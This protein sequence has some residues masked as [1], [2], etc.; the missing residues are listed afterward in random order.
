[1]MLELD[2]R[3]E[4]AA[5]YRLACFVNMGCR[6][7]EVVTF[8]VEFNDT[9]V[10]EVPS[11]ILDGREFAGGHV[12]A[13]PRFL[14][15]GRRDCHARSYPNNGLEPL[16]LPT[17]V[18]S[19]MPP[20]KGAG[21]LQH[22]AVRMDRELPRHNLPS[23]ESI[24]SRLDAVFGRAVHPPT[25]PGSVPVSAAA[26]TQSRAATSRSRARLAIRATPGGPR[27]SSNPVGPR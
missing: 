11:R 21:S 25:N 22:G 27:V 5:S 15:G 3:Y 19:M 18:P 16:K 7:S 2:Q 6:P 1:M 4:L 12:S 24:R 26:A 8:N 20:D 10:D 13:N 23:I 9:L 17:A 14:F